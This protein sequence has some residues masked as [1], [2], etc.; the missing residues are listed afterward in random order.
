MTFVG[1]NWGQDAAQGA[2]N[3]KDCYQKDWSTG[4][5]GR[6]KS[7]YCNAANNGKPPKAAELAYSVFLLTGERSGQFP[8][9]YVPRWTLN[10]S[11]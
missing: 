6:L 5:L 8:G 7:P 3:L 11:R 9:T 2:L 10:E 1:R 4:N